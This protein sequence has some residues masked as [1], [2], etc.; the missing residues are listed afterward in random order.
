M[1]RRR[2][3]GGCWPTPGQELLLRACLSTGN[4]ASD[5]FLEWKASADIGAVDPGSYRLFP[6]LYV[7]LKSMGIDDPLMNIFG[8]V[9][10]KTASNNRTLYGR[11]S[12]LL[13]ELG[14]RGMP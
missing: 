1:S 2:N 4:E 9:Y 5:A 6:L 7:N 14:G 13:S 10:A 12:A 11:L 3:Y 8:W